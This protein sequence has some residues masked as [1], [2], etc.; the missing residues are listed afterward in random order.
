MPQA[1]SALVVLEV[2]LAGCIIGFSALMLATSLAS[3]SRLR[4]ARFAYVSA[5][6][7]LLLLE[8][9]LAMAGALIDSLKGTFSV[10][11][12]IL[13]IELLI[14]IFLYLAVAKR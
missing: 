12:S 4:H 14:L 5:A 9:I 1:P 11:D 10:P 13:G 7:F 6:F 8:G 3:Y 2:F